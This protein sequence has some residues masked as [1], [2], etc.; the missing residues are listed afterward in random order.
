MRDAFKSMTRTLLGNSGRKAPVALAKT[1]CTP[2]PSSISPLA[3]LTS[4]RSAPPPQSEGENSATNR[5]RNG[6]EIMRRQPAMPF[7]AAH[8]RQHAQPFG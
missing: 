6:Q 4:T 2:M 8:L 1:T 7:L 5:W 3:R